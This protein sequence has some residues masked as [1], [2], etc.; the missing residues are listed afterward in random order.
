MIG[1]SGSVQLCDYCFDVCEALTAVIGD[2][3]TNDVQGTA[4]VE[5]EDLGRCVFRLDALLL[6]TSLL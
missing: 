4:P 2:G 1:D 3:N 5:L 6:Y